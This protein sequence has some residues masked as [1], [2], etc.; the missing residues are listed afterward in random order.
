MALPTIHHTFRLVADPVV[1]VLP[2]GNA[3]AKLRL[4]A[5]SSKKNEA[6]EWVDADRFFIDATAFGRVAE[7]VAE[8]DL[9]QGDEVTARGRI[10]TGEWETGEWETAEGEKRSGDE[11]LVDELARPVRVPRRSDAGTPRT[12]QQGDPW[13]ARPAP[14]TRSFSNEPPF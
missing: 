12:V 5:N 8:A 6:G 2:S 11:L 1:R 4:A 10:K 3:L 9:R 14:A 7:A 13:A